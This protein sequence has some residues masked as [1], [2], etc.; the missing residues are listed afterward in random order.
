[1]REFAWHLEF[2]SSKKD[3]NVLAGRDSFA[4]GRNDNVA[5]RASGGH[6]VTGALPADE[7]D[8]G[9]GK[10]AGKDSG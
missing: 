3:G 8:L 7:I 10:R 6:Y 1:M 4:I 9:V 5:I 2:G